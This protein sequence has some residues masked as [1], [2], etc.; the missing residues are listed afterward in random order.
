MYKIS[1]L[2]P[3]LFF[4]KVKNVM[5]LFN[6]LKIFDTQ[7]SDICPTLIFSF[8]EKGTK[9]PSPLGKRGLSCPK[10]QF[11]LGKKG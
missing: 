8:K 11:S 2:H 4:L 6:G 5:S 7:K 9:L 3:Y 1:C 10:E